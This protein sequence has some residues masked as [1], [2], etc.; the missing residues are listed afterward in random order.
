MVDQ[1]I[2]CPSRLSGHFLY[3][4]IVRQEGK[5]ENFVFKEIAKTCPALAKAIP[6]DAAGYAFN[7][8]ETAF[9]KL[10]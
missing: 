6:I 10:S 7:F 4:N 3:V 1:N 8:G 5:N 9:A 2:P